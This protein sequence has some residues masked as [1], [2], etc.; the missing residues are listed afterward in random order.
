MSHPIH[1]DPLGALAKVG[2]SDGFTNWRKEK[3]EDAELLIPSVGKTVRVNSQRSK[4]P[5]GTEGVVFFFGISKYWREP[6]RGKWDRNAAVSGLF[7][8]DNENTVNRIRKGAYRVGF[9]T[10]DGTKH[11]CS[12]TCVEIIQSL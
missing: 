1:R 2:K 6:I 4:V 9:T 8:T 3:A 7:R 12:A 10:S 5:H 11:F